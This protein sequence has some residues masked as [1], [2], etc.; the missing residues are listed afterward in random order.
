MLWWEGHYS[1]SSVNH[2]HTSQSWVPVSSCMRQRVTPRSSECP[3]TRLRGRTCQLLCNARLRLLSHDQYKVNVMYSALRLECIII[4]YECSRGYFSAFRCEE[5]IY[6]CGS[7]IHRSDQPV[8]KQPGKSRIRVTHLTHPSLT[9]P[10]GQERF[11][12]PYKLCAA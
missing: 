2:S 5:V 8:C 1:A 10:P 4:C 3:V 12:N 11:P 7:L 9:L 6:W